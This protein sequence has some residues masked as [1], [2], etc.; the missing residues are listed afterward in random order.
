MSPVRSITRE[1]CDELMGERLAPLPLFVV[2]GKEVAH[3]SQKRMKPLDRVL[4]ITAALWGIG[5]FLF[6]LFGVSD[7]RNQY[8][9]W[10]LPFGILCLIAGLTA[11]GF[12]LYRGRWR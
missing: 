7:P 4:C 2:V 6:A 5:A 1:E 10:V 9:G 11:A 3:M 12:T 8:P